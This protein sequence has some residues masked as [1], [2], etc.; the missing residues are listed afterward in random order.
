[1]I[2]CLSTGLLGAAP[3]P[4]PASA[5]PKAYFVFTGADI[6]TEYAGQSHQVV[7]AKGSS[8]E[9]KTGMET[10]VVPARRVNGYLTVRGTKLSTVKATIGALRAESLHLALDRQN[11]EFELGTAS[12]IRNEERALQDEKAQLQIGQMALGAA[13]A[14]TGEREKQIEEASVRIENLRDVVDDYVTKRP[15]EQERS[16]ERQLAAA[17]AAAG[18][19]AALPALPFA[20]RNDP[21]ADGFELK[22]TVSSPQPLDRAYL[23]VTLVYVDRAEPRKKQT[24]TTLQ[25][26]SPV[27]E[28]PRKVTVTLRGLPLG[29]YLIGCQIGLYGNGQEVATNVSTTEEAMTE[30]QV[31]QY[32]LGDYLLRNRDQTLPPAPLLLAPPDELRRQVN[33]AGLEQVIYASI[34]EQGSIVALSTDET[35]ARDVPPQILTALRS[36]RFFPGLANGQPVASRVKLKPSDL[37]R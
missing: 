7:G 11:A 28:K 5:T 3:K 25:P 6:M 32:F 4:A 1:V 12:A 26:L 27:T 34:D 10:A 30:E 17:Q 18:R 13:S 35:E 9:I 21:A 14:N 29:F 2:L 37:L 8:L 24:R 22:G 19:R 23:A 15:D 20:Y 16:R 31:Y 33:A 36:V